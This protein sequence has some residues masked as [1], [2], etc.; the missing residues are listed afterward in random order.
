MLLIPPGTGLVFR[1]GIAAFALGH[2]AYGAAFLSLG[3]APA[4]LALGALAALPLIALAWRHLGPH[5][6]GALRGA[7]A[8][9][10]AIVSAMAVLAIAAS[11]HGAPLALAAGGVA[12]AISDLSVARDR[13]VAAS[14][15]N[16]AW[17]LPLYFAAQLAIAWGVSAP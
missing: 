6:A 17:G 3:V 16:R 4:A 10:L 12:F 13:F 14:L 5:L 9:Y 1:L 8:A 2:I 11:A 7:V 15:V